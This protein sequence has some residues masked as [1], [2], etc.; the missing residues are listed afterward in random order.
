VIVIFLIVV[1]I[2]PADFRL[3]R[4]VAIDAPASAVFPYVNELR[5]FDDWSPFAKIDPN[6]KKTYEGPEAGV[7]A[8]YSWNGNDNAGEGKMTIVESRPGEVV[9]MK[10]EFTRPMACENKVEFRFEPKGD[11]THVSWIMTG[12][13]GF[14]GKAFHLLLVD[15]MVGGQFEEGL[16]KLK[17]LSEADA[18]KP[19][20]K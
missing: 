2:Q 17:S 12:T 3:A 8:S 9:F 14:I 5:R 13:N 7:G 11:Q 10:L 16:A 18:K 4:T 19:V 1:A 15:R 20:G 6:M